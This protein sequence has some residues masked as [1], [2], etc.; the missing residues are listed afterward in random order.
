MLRI[1]TLSLFVIIST[2]LTAQ[3]DSLTF[4][5]L[6]TLPAEKWD[7]TLRTDL[8][9]YSS[10]QRVDILEKF[11]I[12]ASEKFGRVSPQYEKVRSRLRF[13]Y[14]ALARYE[15]AGRGM[16]EVKELREQLY[17]SNSREYL[18]SLRD[19]GFFYRDTED[20]EKAEYYLKLYESR[21]RQVFGKNS[22][23]YVE[24]LVALVAYYQFVGEMDKM[25]SN[26]AQAI[27]VYEQMNGERN[28][29]YTGLLHNMGIVYHDLNFLDKA[30][31][32]YKQAIALLEEL[33][34]TENSTYFGLANSLGNLYLETGR[35]DEAEEMYE[36]ESSVREKTS[37]VD[38]PFA[39]AS[40]ISNKVKI[41]VAKKQYK[42]A[43]PLMEQELEI[44]KTL[45]GTEIHS[46]YANGVM[47]AAD[48]YI[49]LGKDD[50]AEE[51]YHQAL[52]I[53]NQTVG[54][55]H[56]F[57]LNCQ[58][59]LAAF[60]MRKQRSEEAEKALEHV[61]A[62]Y[63]LQLKN[64][65]PTFSERERLDFAKN[66]ETNIALVY[67][68][69][70]SPL[71]SPDFL[72]ETA[73]FNLF[74]KGLILENTVGAK[75]NAVTSS[76]PALKVTYL[77]WKN[78]RKKISDNLTASESEQASLQAETD[79]LQNLANAL[80]KQ[81]S[82]ESV[83]FTAPQRVRLADVAGQLAVGEV[84]IDIL[85][86]PFYGEE[87]LIDSV[88]YYALIIKKGAQQ[89]EL[90]YLTDEKKL[91]RILG[92]SSSRYVE[93]PQIGYDLY[94]LVWKPLEEKLGDSKKIY[95][96]PGGLLHQVSYA[97]LP[98]VVTGTP[99]LAD[100]YEF[101]YFGNLKDFVLKQNESAVAK[102]IT[103][104]GGA[105]FELDSTELIQLALDRNSTIAP[106]SPFSDSGELLAYNSTRSLDD[107]T[108]SAIVFN[109]LPGTKE[110]AA[111][112]GEKFTA[113]Q[114]DVQLLT[115]KQALEDNLKDLSGSNAPGILHIAT[116]GYF[117][118]QHEKSETPDGTLRERI[119]TSDNPLLR[120]GL[121]FTGV[122]YAWLGGKPISGLDDGVLTAYE[123]SMLD[124]FPTNLVVL[125]ACETGKGDILNGEGVFGLQRAFKSA[126]VENLIISLW[127]VPDR[128]T[129]ELM[130]A[131]YDYYLA[132]DTIR[133]AFRK[134]QRKMRQLYEPYY[135]A[136]F[137][138][139]E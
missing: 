110:E 31:A 15:E 79:S 95:I 127:K 35:L 94:Q 88:L 104:L 48:F 34:K 54:P 69:A 3:Q 13:S 11:S 77:N 30:E 96:S 93:Y 46:Y 10:Q 90:V 12:A 108:R 139:M 107:S 92:T 119:A 129:T 14:L 70:T 33:G 41:L 100:T 97:A 81:L 63:N 40:R 98:T 52:K 89:P 74:T 36:I 72:A 68:F 76:D 55:W 99:L 62:Y 137:V 28:E 50:K 117:F 65:Y 130:Q 126:G 135:W 131:F 4:E 21:I 45:Y 134:A 121:V 66:L 120:S 16:E 8:R 83:A 17:G 132:G 25:E 49:K 85:Q 22:Q 19:Y 113:A 116:H 23:P 24:A 111:S 133:T 102:S 114:W 18:N 109:Y 101:T 84:A 26:M 73:D 71:A 87:G 122:N 64:I 78:L 118:A 60:Q 75:I 136:G 103:V 53:Y 61:L 47:D 59:K 9:S 6:A 115:E 29:F 32:Y 124:F 51:L 39:K 1:Y 82:Q 86:F 44:T 123:I 7:S 37:G 106:E 57:T 27:A 67:T 91:Q 105:Q 80:E 138:L 5:R 42:E 112:I 128:Q 125:S 58:L 20:P 38:N 56:Y 2:N 43:E